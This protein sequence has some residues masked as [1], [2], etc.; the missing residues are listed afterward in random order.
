M[1]NNFS[2]RFDQKLKKDLEAA[3]KATGLKK[4]DLIR[5]CVGGY[6]QTLRDQ[7]TKKAS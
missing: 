1:K 3:E 7:L 6:I 2:I 5:L 4:A